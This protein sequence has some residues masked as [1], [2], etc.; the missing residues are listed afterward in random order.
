MN[1]IETQRYAELYERIYGDY[2]REEVEVH[3]PLGGDDE[4][5]TVID[6]G[7]GTG[8]QLRNVCGR[9]S[10]AKSC[11]I[12]FDAN[13]HMISRAKSLSAKYDQKKLFFEVSDFLRLSLNKMPAR[14][15]RNASLVFLCLGNTLAL[16]VP[17]RLPNLVASLATVMTQVGA[18]SAT[19]FLETRSG[20][21]YSEWINGGRIEQL[22]YDAN[23]EHILLSFQALTSQGN[24]YTTRIYSLYK[25]GTRAEFCFL[26]EPMAHFVDLEQ[27]KSALG[28]K[29]NFSMDEIF[30]DKGGTISG[31]TKGHVF[32]FKLNLK[33]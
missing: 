8:G 30:D 11:F 33:T 16:I 7:C 28:E 1:E 13:E 25:N 14:C 2:L 24:V 10:N 22:N 23:D 12:G 32:Q 6:L 5:L 15:D 20:K 26:E 17:E 4:L 19:L 27:V 18:R 9:N 3:L 29:F 21:D 31:L